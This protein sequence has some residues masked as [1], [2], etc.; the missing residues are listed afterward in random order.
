MLTKKLFLNMMEAAEN[1]DAEL[2]RWD[3]FGID[4]FEQPIGEIPWE[5]FNT[6]MDCHF[7]A[8]G[9]DW[10]HWY[11]WERKGLMTGEV[12]AC[13]EPD[14]TPFYI[15]NAQDLWPLVEPH[16]LKTCLDSPCTLKSGQCI[17]S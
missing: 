12:L 13:Y 15:N 14:G 4:V 10:I 8:D 2:Q 9:K 1:F 17:N 3:D 11:L 16:L 6:W 7:D 5:M